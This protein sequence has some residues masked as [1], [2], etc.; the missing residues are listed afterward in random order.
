MSANRFIVLVSP[1][2]RHT[3]FTYGDIV[4]V[5]NRFCVL[6]RTTMLEDLLKKVC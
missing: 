5:S 3:W 1:R 4:F 6:G 2:M